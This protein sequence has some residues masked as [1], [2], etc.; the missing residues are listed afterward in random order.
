MAEPRKGKSEAGGRAVHAAPLKPER[1]QAHAFQAKGVDLIFRIFDLGTRETDGTVSLELRQ[2]VEV[3]GLLVGP[4]GEAKAGSIVI[5]AL[6]LRVP[7][8][9]REARGETGKRGRRS[10]AAARRAAPT[11]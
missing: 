7:A 11:P 6:R 3:P 9:A 2:P 5:E 10:V 8:P 4:G 1:V